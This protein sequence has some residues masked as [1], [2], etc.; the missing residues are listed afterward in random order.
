MTTEQAITELRN[1]SGLQF[2]PELVES[3]IGIVSNLAF[4]GSAS[5][6]EAITR[7]A[8]VDV[9]NQIENLIAAIDDQDIERLRSLAD[10]LKSTAQASGIRR[11]AESASSLETAV[12]ENAELLSILVSAS[13]LVG[14]CR[15]TQKT[16]LNNT[17][18]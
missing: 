8:A 1:G 13:E 15:S 7:D 3:L 4:Q 18:S 6:P 5:Q 16:L 9:G 10:R 12:A 2:D 17:I 14:L 11:V